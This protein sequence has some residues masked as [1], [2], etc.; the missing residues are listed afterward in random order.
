[1]RSRWHGYWGLES[2]SEAEGRLLRPCLCGF[3][4]RRTAKRARCPSWLLSTGIVVRSERHRIYI[5]S[6]IALAFQS[7]FVL[8]VRSHPGLRR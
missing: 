7:S 3:S 8:V 5:P 4:G 6:V 1:Q 2:A